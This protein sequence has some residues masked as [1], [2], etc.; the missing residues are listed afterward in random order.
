MYK[1]RQASKLI[2]DV[3]PRNFVFTIELKVCGGQEVASS[4]DT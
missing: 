2:K 3:P 1:T 4:L